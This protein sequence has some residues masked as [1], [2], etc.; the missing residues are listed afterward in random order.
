VR[1]GLQPAYVLHLQPFRDTSALLETWTQDV[2]RVALVARGIQR[3]RSL[4][5]GLLQPFRPLLLSWTGKGD[6]GT[7]THAESNGAPLALGGRLLLSGFYVNELLLRLT[8]RHDAH[9]QLF[10]AYHNVLA[11]LAQVACVEGDAALQGHGEQWVLRRFEQQL[12]RE[13]GYGLQLQREAVSGAPVT[14]DATYHYDIERGPLRL[15]QCPPPAWA[16]AVRGS[17]LLAIARDD[18]ADEQVMRDAKRLLRLALDHHLAGRDLASRRLRK[19]Y[20]RL[21][22]QSRGADANQP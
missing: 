21:H 17:S 3:P 9:P 7:L 13:C 4:L 6:M 5:K 19:A 12:L 10:L 20:E 8:Q 16:V 15:S 2:G 22:G 11:G 14:E 18:L 1:I